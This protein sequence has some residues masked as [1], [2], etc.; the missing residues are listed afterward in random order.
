MNHLVEFQGVSSVLDLSNFNQMAELNDIHVDLANEHSLAF[1]FAAVD[2][3]SNKAKINGLRLAKNNINGLVQM[4]KIKF[5]V[6]DLSCND[7]RI[8]LLELQKQCLVLK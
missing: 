8:C 5:D 6:L 4:P 1:L 3:L 2:K 7:V